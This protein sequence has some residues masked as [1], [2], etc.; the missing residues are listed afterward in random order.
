MFWFTVEKIK[1]CSTNQLAV[2]WTMNNIIVKSWNSVPSQSV[3]ATYSSTESR[4]VGFTNSSRP[5]SIS[6]MSK[7]D[8]VKLLYASSWLLVLLHVNTFERG[9]TNSSVPF[10]PIRVNLKIQASAIGLSAKEQRKE[11]RFLKNTASTLWTLVVSIEGK[12]SKD[13]V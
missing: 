2:H 13:H 12:F 3:C 4:T 10:P 9:T 7:S 6:F 8:T 1:F 5:P 11:T